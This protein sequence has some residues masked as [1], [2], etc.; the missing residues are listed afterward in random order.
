MNQSW[1]RMFHVPFLFI[2][3]MFEVK[4]VIGS[5]FC[6]SSLADCEENLKDEKIDNNN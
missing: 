4:N 6:K 2:L 3:G 1:L 5:R